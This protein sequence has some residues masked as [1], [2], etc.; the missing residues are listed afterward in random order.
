MSASI[1]VGEPK[2]LSEAKTIS[3][4]VP[5]TGPGI[6]AKTL[7]PRQIEEVSFWCVQFKEHA[8]FLYL[9][10]QPSPTMTS[11]TPG[12]SA[13]P[14]FA[15]SQKSTAENS[16]LIL[17]LKQR[18]RQLM[19]SW[20]AF[21]KMVSDGKIDVPILSNLVNHTRYIKSRIMDLQAKKVWVGALFPEFVEHLR[22]ELDYFV[23]R[24]ND[25]ISPDEE[26]IFWLENNA[27]HLAFVAHLLN[28]DYKTSRPVVQEALKLSDEGMAAMSILSTAP[29]DLLQLAE[30]SR[31]FD[32]LSYANRTDSLTQS[33]WN[34]GNITLVGST[35]HP[36][37]IAHII[38][39]GLRSIKRLTELGSP[40]P[41][42]AGTAYHLLA[43][44][45]QRAAI[46]R[47]GPHP[48]FHH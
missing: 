42:T 14:G 30:L 31:R 36:A 21:E 35:I 15:A 17:K 25:Q 29:I 22:D 9:G 19:S 37:M 46:N 3:R 33:L 32:H 1:T 11:T 20:S 5:A 2:P 18:S 27:E 26:K 39:E 23:A 12:W 24:F 16:K 13:L 38:R 10:L 40:P 41:K 7:S 34:G 6:R 48:P 45:V 47:P 44:A 28:T 8:L 4:V 43:H